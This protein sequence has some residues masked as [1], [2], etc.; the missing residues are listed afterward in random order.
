M[1]GVIPDHVLYRLRHHATMQFEEP[2]E[3]QAARFRHNG[4]TEFVP[5][6]WGRIGWGF[7][8]TDLGRDIISHRIDDM[9]A[10]IAGAKPSDFE[11]APV[12]EISRYNVSLTP[13]CD[14]PG[15]PHFGVGRLP[16]AS[17]FVLDDDDG[18]AIFRSFEDRWF[19]VIARM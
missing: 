2:R 10:T 5:C 15:S 7:W 3:I 14:E 19:Y 9:A 17:G 4:R 16:A 8:I 18:L 11:T 6:V 1:E 13:R 12:I